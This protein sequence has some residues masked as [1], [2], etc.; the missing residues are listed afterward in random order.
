[1]SR[2][3]TIWIAF[4]AVLLLAPQ[5]SANTRSTS[6]R[7]APNFPGLSAADRAALDIQKTTASVA[8]GVAQV[9]VQMRGS[10]EARLGRGGLRDAVVAIVLT[11]RRGE[12]GKP[13]V[14][15]TR[16]ANPGKVIR[17][18]RTKD[19]LVTR[20]GRQL[21]F[22]IV[23]PGVEKVGSI[24]VKAFS[25]VAQARA[26]GDTTLLDL[27]QELNAG[28]ELVLQGLT[29]ES[30]CVVLELIDESIGNE[31]KE[32]QADIR[33]ARGDERRGL[34]MQ[35]GSANR[36]RN[37][38]RKLREEL[39]QSPSPR[40]LEL[41]FTVC[42]GPHGGATS[43]FNIDIEVRTPAARAAS[44]DGAGT[45][46]TVTLAGPSDT[47]IVGDKTKSATL[48]AAGKG[49]FDFTITQFGNY[50]V[51]ATGT[52]AAGKPISGSTQFEV[53]S[54]QTCPT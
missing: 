44:P 43:P 9:T 40:P 27:I 25:K 26:S 16:G 23:G 6:D 39:C 37:K 7:G 51:D 50:T 41:V 24:E 53:K 3:G 38:V 30:A 2:Q 31:I 35:I 48:D 54:G 18:T 33:A 45:K 46:L 13:A 5:A 32:L 49:E 10:V 28:D 21:S 42:S 14:V 4:L 11:P 17:N 22:L 34:S 29:V 47:A 8:N 36:L 15:G 52:T 12:A 19:V 20:N 1:V